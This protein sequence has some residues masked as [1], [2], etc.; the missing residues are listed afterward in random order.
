MA[1]Y[2]YFTLHSVLNLHVSLT[3]TT[4]GVEIKKFSNVVTE[5]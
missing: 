3:L 2:I 5:Y 1:F 4:T